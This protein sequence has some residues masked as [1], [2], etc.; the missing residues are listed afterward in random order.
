MTNEI[1]FAPLRDGARMPQKRE[2]DAGYDIYACFDEPWR[3]IAPHETTL[4]PSG[5]ISAFPKEYV[6]ILKER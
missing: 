6:A 1:L 4:V 5:L 2:E 3:I